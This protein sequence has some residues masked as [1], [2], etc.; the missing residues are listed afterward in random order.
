MLLLDAALSG[1]SIRISS[2]QHAQ[3][4]VIEI[5]RFTL[6][7]KSDD[8]WSSSGAG[9]VNGEDLAFSGS[10]QPTGALLAGRPLTY[11]L[12]ATAGAIELQ[13]SG[14]FEDA[15]DGKGADLEA[16]LQGP[17]VRRLLG[18]LGLPALSEGAFDFRLHLDTEGPSTRIALD[19]DLGTLQARADGEVDRLLQPTSGRLETQVTG[20]D[21]A[22]VGQVFD[23]RGLPG[24]HYR[25]DADAEFT[26]GRVNVGSLTLQ[27]AGS[28]VAA[29]GVLATG[30]GLA[31]SDLDFELGLADAGL[32]GALAGKRS[33]AGA[34]PA[35][36]LTVDGRL[37]VD[38]EGQ[39][40]LKV[41]TGFAENILLV[42]GRIGIPGRQL[43]PDLE[44]DFH[45]PGLQSLRPLVESV[46]AQQAAD[47][48]V[49]RY[50]PAAPAAL[51][52]RV[53]GTADLLVLEDVEAEVGGHRLRLSGPLNPRPPFT[54]SRLD[55]GLSS[56]NLAELGALFGQGGLPTAV[57]DVTGQ[58]SRPD[59]QIHLDGVALDLAGHRARVDGAF[60]PGERL[61]GSRFEARLESPDL[62]QLGALLGQQG[63]PPK[64]L[65]LDL[66]LQPEGRGLA[67]RARSTEG[68]GLRLDVDGSIPDLDHPL[69]IDAA[70][71]IQLPSLA[72][73]GAWAPGGRFPDLPLTARGR[74]Q[75]QQQGSRLDDVRLEMGG[76][77][78][79]LSGTLGRPPEADGEPGA[80]PSQR[81]QFDLELQASAA[82]AS[83]LEQWGAAP[84]PP[85]PVS[86][87]LHLA[88][89]T[90][91]FEASSVDARLGRTRLGGDLAVKLGEPRR[92][93]GRIHAPLLDLA[94]WRGDPD[95]GAPSPEEPAPTDPGG[96]V[97]DDTPVTGLVD[98][99]VELDLQFGADEIDLGNTLIR[100]LAVG[101][102][103]HGRRLDLTTF[104]LRGNK[105]GRLTGR[106]SL[107]GSGVPQLSLDLDAKDLR[108][109][110]A[111]APDQDPS[112][113]PAT[114]IRLSLQGTGMTRRELASGLD[115]EF[116]LYS[117]PGQVASS[118]VTLLFSDFLAE[119]L[120]TLN[121]FS[122][123]S[124]YTQMECTVAAVD[125]V[126]G[127]AAVGPVV[128]QTKEITILSQGSIDLRTE[129]IDLS[130]NTKARTG[131]G[132]TTGVLI[133]PLIKVGGRLA[134]PAIEL[135][136][137]RAVV[138][139]GTAVATAG[140][141]LLA[142]GF[143]D[144]FL[145]SKDPCG[146]AREDITKRDAS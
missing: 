117:G 21:L 114:D 137:A 18:Y 48:R 7:A 77:Q 106:A 105:G 25:L 57:L 3:P 124:A 129:Q 139:G 134:R 128:A 92:L 115:G 97:F 19:G 78:V 12:H 119:L 56:P 79:A 127:Q 96:Y 143:S 90:E 71:D 13:S 103:L 69:G 112:T 27:S 35:G 116:R 64:P 102:E 86:L 14:A 109:G 113:Y 6:Q 44:V 85:D 66:S 130:F 65:T 108:L 123:K 101:V 74:L 120:Q 50:L 53:S 87:G 144:R 42:D 132:I 133:N 72:W 80:G 52:G 146:D 30:A 29:S 98:Y 47:P 73:L 5:T 93:S 91:A 110:L 59:R 9:S 138:S 111:A 125:I 75:N 39:A 49:E 60:A 46:L 55:A 135:D 141:S 136:P 28:R 81:L 45:S 118:S 61:L 100:D 22:A 145:S 62:A 36:P 1:C 99:G 16:R 43:Q 23:I 58:L 104:S 31:G 70:V 94:F 95:A 32:L 11:E 15:L 41:R 10:L 4:T 89:N 142:K 63:L 122:K 40:E 84:L 38:G 121:P 26:P 17:E 20:P 68:D 8:G 76:V 67:F 37:L 140:L 34:P 33:P 83:V 24:A 126:D 51:R 82:D 107:D 2:R 54:G 131:L 88:G